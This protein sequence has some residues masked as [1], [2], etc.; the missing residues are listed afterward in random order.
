M[1][2]QPPLAD[3]GIG[4]VVGNGELGEDAEEKLVG[5]EGG[6]IGCRRVK[7]TGRREGRE[8]GERVKIKRVN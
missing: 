5:E 1:E 7:G 4:E 6:E 2:V 3:E 8:T